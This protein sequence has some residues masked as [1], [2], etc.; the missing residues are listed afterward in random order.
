MLLLET[1]VRANLQ[2]AQMQACPRLDTIS[3]EEDVA[4][5]SVDLEVEVLAAIGSH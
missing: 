1:W 5:A 4:E 3:K 2:L